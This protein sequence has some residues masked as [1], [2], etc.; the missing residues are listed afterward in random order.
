MQVWDYDIP[1]NWQP[2]TDQ[3]WEWFLV[4]K[5]NYDD[6]D[7]LKKETIKKHFPKIKKHLDPGKRAMLEYFFNHDTD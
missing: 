1:A 7:G 2:A 6:F 4:R 5:I 3:E